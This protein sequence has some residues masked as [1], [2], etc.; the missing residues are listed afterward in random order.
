MIPSKVTMFDIDIDALTMKQTV[1]L[2]NKG[3]KEGNQIVHSCINAYLVVLM[4]KNASLRHRLQQADIISADGQSV[5][6]ASHL[7]HHPLP[8]RVPGPDLMNAL[9]F[10]AAEEDYKVFLLG[11][12]EEVVKNVA[13]H[14]GKTF[15][16]EIV[17]GLRNGY[18]NEGDESKIVAEINNS[19]AQILFVALPS[20][21]KEVFI[22]KYR[23]Q[24]P[25]ILLLMGVGGSF[26]VIAG[27]VK[28]APL[29][30]QKIGTE[31]L[32]RLLQEPRK[33]WKRYLIGNIEFL[34]L[35]LKNKSKFET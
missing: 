6:W 4:D 28:R 10:L 3:I 26:D 7:Y 21:K 33:M 20:P 19:G 18:F 9:M 13:S 8:E 11:A 30:M 24:L 2:I 1:E 15:H 14:Y 35:L 16:N 5:V 25:N 22:N 29:W 12:K 32:Y 31:W 23:H 17:S 34:F 27:K